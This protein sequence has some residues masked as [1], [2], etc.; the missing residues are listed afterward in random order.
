M[1]QQNDVIAKN[2]LSFTFL[3]LTPIAMVTPAVHFKNLTER[4]DDLP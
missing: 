2:M 3:F 1:L 4:M